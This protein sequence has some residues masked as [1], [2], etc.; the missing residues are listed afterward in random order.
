MCAW[1]CGG[2]RH[3]FVLIIRRALLSF[4]SSSSSYCLAVFR[5]ERFCFRVTY[6]ARR[7]ERGRENGTWPRSEGAWWG[8]APQSRERK[9]QGRQR[10]QARQGTARVRQPHR[11]CLSSCILPTRT[12]ATRSRTLMWCP[13]GDTGPN[14]SYM[15]TWHDWRYEFI[16]SSLACTRIN[17][18]TSRPSRRALPESNTSWL[19]TSTDLG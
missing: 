8:A 12:G 1:V 6:L 13:T 3:S 4:S 15:Y 14:R 7:R 10:G 18:S 19:S 2:T 9:D 5:C 16:W 17:A 11:W